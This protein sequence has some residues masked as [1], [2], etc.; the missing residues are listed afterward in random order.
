MSNFNLLRSEAAA[1]KARV[2]VH[3]YDVDLDLC[4]AAD[5]SI[6]G[7]S[8]RT[9]I[10]FSATG[11][12][13]TFLD[14]IG[15]SVESVELNGEQLNVAD[16]VDAQR[17][18]L[19]TL[20]ADNEVTVC[21]TAAYSS[22]GEGLHRFVDPADGQTYTYTQYEP[23]DARRVFANFEQPDLK[24]PF[25]FHVTANSDWEVASNQSI[26][27][28]AELPETGASR[29]DFATTAPIS[30]Y[31]T[32]ILAGPYFKAQDHFSMVF[33]DE[34]SHPGETLEIPL[35]AY[36]RASLAPH[37]DTAEIFKVTKAG[38]KYFNELF[39]FPY[40]FGK[41]D[42]AFVPEYNLGAMENPGLVTFTEAYIYTSRTTDT[43]YQRRATTIM[44][45]MAHMWF[46]DLVTMSWWDDLWLKESFADFMGNLAVAEATP[47]GPKAWTMFAS[48]RKAWAYT[49]DQLPTTHPITADIPDLEAAK[50]NFDGITYAKGASALKQL[51]AYVG[52]D[53]FVAGSREYFKTHQYSNTKLNDL[54]A[55]LSAASGRDLSEWAKLWLQT[56][57]MST[58][59]PSIKTADGKIASLSI[60]QDAIDPIT[61]LEALRPHRLTVGIFMYDAGSLVRTHSIALDVTGEVTEVPRAAGLPTPDL[62]LIND[63]DHSYAKVR[64]DA[65]SLAA[66]LTSVKTIADPLSRSLV[67]SALWNATRDALLPAEQYLAAVVDQAGGDS[68]I[69][70]LQTLADNALEALNSY[71]PAANRPAARERLI[72]G[73]TTHLANAVPSSDEQLVWARTLARLGRGTDSLIKFSRALLSG[74]AVPGGLSVDGSLRWLL[75]QQL[76]A[77]GAATQQELDAELAANT[78][79][80][81]RASH[82]TAIAA[83]PDAQ[84]K[85]RRWMEIVEEETLSNQLLGATIAGFTMAGPD[86]LDP[87]TEPYFQ[88]IERVWNGRSLE[89]AGRIVRGL[90]PAHQDLLPGTEPERHPVVVRTDAWLGGHTTATHGLR[91]IVLEQRDQLVRALRAQAQQA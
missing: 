66:A 29:W 44:H 52:Q 18:N 26:T 48:Q 82:C 70:L 78:T 46:G 53:A 47:W 83:L 23:A 30:T 41:Y 87:Y 64:F 19:P 20:A 86:L 12:A 39:D 73:V 3:H 58:L 77:R 28:R 76:A 4:Q 50:A 40:P 34:S 8:S 27:N 5:L 7:F 43:A 15:L 31:I 22:S 71:C 85:S 35:A 61:G 10:K 91:R 57:G 51:V 81:Y 32:T 17:I 24:A 11:T 90:F 74:Q 67:W 36:C 2:S 9:T 13:G 14:F 60:R 1:R 21:A 69:S 72:A 63:E 59:A 37:F 75:W 89:I 33:G 84:L 38:L 88:A 68:D 6:P 42:Q 49:Q 54:L 62:L 56:S 79:A 80:E 25:T 16:V 55:P 65:G 45:E